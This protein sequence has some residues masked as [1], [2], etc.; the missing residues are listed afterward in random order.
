[1]ADLD[2]LVHRWFDAVH[3]RDGV[4]MG[5]LYANDC[6]HVRSSGTSRGRGAIVSYLMGLGAGFPDRGARIVSSIV[7]RDTV[8]VEWIETGTHTLPYDAGALERSRP[9]AR[10]SRRGSWTCSGSSGTSSPRNTSTTDSA[11]SPNLVGSA[12]PSPDAHFEAP[13]PGNLRLSA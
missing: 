6:E 13:S 4:A 5:A 7:A 11:C 3:A 1:M 12:E 8:T 9:R 10:R 2:A